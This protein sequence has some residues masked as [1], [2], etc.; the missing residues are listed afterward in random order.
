[1]WIVV[2]LL[3]LA[4]L[5]WWTHREREDQP[6]PVENV[7]VEMSDGTYTDGNVG[8]AHDTHER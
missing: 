4:G 3:A 2:F 5:Y 1:M 7:Q 8:P 6:N